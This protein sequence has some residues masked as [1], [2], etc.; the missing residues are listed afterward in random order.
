MYLRTT[1]FENSKVVV[2][3]YLCSIKVAFDGKI[4]IVKKE[5]SLCSKEPYFMFLTVLFI[6]GFYI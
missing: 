6:D 4:F 3:K 2:L 5:V 1:I